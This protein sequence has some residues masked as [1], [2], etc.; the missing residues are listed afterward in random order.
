MIRK[1][2]LGTVL[3]LTSMT[4][5]FAWENIGEIETTYVRPQVSSFDAFASA[6]RAA[7]VVKLDKS[8]VDRHADVSNQ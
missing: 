2:A 5:A 6:R 4:G 7:P 3:A 1:I 8:I